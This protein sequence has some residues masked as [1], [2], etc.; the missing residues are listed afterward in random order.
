MEIKTTLRPGENGTKALLRQYGDQLVCVRYRYDKV[1][2]KRY[3]TVEL[4]VDESPWVPST[5]YAMDKPVFLRVGYNELELRERV[6]ASGGFWDV[7]RKAWRLE[8]RKAIELGL[9]DRIL[10]LN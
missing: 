9:E 7:R 8:F 3:K 2:R 4:I 1:R 10:G 6:K 5:S